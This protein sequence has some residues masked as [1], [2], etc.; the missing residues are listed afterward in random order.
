MAEIGS[1]A[2]ECHAPSEILSCQASSVAGG[3]LS[4]GRKSVS[5]QS[6]GNRA[7]TDVTDGCRKQQVRGIAGQTVAEAAD[8]AEN[9]T[10]DAH[11][12]INAYPLEKQH[13][14]LLS[15]VPASSV[16]FRTSDVAIFAL[17]SFP[18]PTLCR[19]PALTLPACHQL[20]TRSLY[21]VPANSWAITLR[22]TASEN[23]IQ[24]D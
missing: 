23:C 13:G 20:H 8:W 19:S 17:E 10:P 12:G 7:K 15:P 22:K 4:F 3:S 6:Q 11:G 18:V 24:R 1:F 5:P 21:R 14:S 2:I 9:Q 16:R